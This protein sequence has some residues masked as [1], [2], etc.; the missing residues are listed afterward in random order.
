MHN[1]FK[2][3]SIWLILKCRTKNVEMRYLPYGSAS[4]TKAKGTKYSLVMKI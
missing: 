4:V 3:N 1:L 2:I